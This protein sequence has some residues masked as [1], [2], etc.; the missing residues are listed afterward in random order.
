MPVTTEFVTLSAA[1]S[2]VFRLIATFGNIRGI[3]VVRWLF[4][5]LGFPNFSALTGLRN[6]CEWYEAGAGGR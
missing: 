6:D 4:V 5:V 1:G 3:G 2:Q